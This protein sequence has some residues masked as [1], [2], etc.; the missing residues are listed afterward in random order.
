MSVPYSVDTPENSPKISHHFALKSE[1]KK[2]QSSICLGWLE[3][4]S[5]LCSAVLHEL[6]V[7]EVFSRRNPFCPLV[8]HLSFGQVR[9]CEQS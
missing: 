6:C 3:F 7:Q 1:L 5:V 8:G 9:G 4:L 2:E